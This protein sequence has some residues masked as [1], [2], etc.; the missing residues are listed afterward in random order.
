MDSSLLKR[1]PVD[2]LTYNNWE[3][4]FY[5]FQEWSKGEGIDYILQKTVRQYAQHIALSF[6]GFG[7]GAT[8][9]STTLSNA[10]PENAVLQLIKVQD[11]LESLQVVED[12]PLCGHWDVVRLEKWSKAEAKMRYTMTICVDDIDSKALKECNTVKDGW[13]SLWSK[14]SNI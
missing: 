1:R 11:L 5:L 10:I 3:E 14:Y 7:S 13:E 9:V 12:L 2:T 8:P 6:S 4:W